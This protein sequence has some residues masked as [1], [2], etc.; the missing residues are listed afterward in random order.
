MISPIS[1]DELSLDGLVVAPAEDGE[2]YVICVG[3]A[4]VMLDADMFQ[5][6]LRD[7]NTMFTANRHG[8]RLDSPPPLFA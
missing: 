2:G 8:R 5:G 6:W 1:A 4:C 7:L 3:G